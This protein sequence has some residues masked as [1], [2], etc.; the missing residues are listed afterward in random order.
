[1]RITNSHFWVLATALAL[2]GS[3]C[4][5]KDGLVKVEGVVTLDGK[6]LEGAMVTFYP[7]GSGHFANGMTD[8][9]G[10]F[11]LTSYQP[12][13]GATPGDYKVTVVWA[14]RG[15]AQ[16]QAQQ[17][18]ADPDVMKAMGRLGQMAAEKKKA[19]ETS[20]LPTIYMKQEHTPLNQR[21]PA[22]GKVV[23]ALRSDIAP[24][25]Q[26]KQTTE[27]PAPDA[28][29]EQKAEPAEK[30]NPSK[31]KPTPKKVK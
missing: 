31:E 26:A 1:M 5:S 28:G 11:T 13:D 29:K 4:G 25:A 20:P 23:L 14:P 7:E 8:K 27:P 2:V 17:D 22:D 10:A 12:G 9:S 21:I 6:P 15:E 19:L 30:G 3:G 18:Q 16:R 24:A